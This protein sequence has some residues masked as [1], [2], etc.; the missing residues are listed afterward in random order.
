MKL[1]TS[2]VFRAYHTKK[3]VVMPHNVIQLRDL[4]QSTVQALANNLGG[5]MM[6]VSGELILF[7]PYSNFC[8]TFYSRTQFTE[9]DK[10]SFEHHIAGYFNT[11]SAIDEIQ[12]RMAS[13]NIERVIK[14]LWNKGS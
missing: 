1:I 14:T 10:G 4:A 12:F 11:T 3:M 5:E 7:N 2:T 13:G 6:N 9:A 8:K